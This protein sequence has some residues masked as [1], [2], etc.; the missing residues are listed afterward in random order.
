MPPNGRG[1]RHPLPFSAGRLPGH[2]NRPDRLP[3]GAGEGSDDE[4]SLEEVLLK[5]QYEAAAACHRDNLLEEANDLF[6]LFGNDWCAVDVATFIM[7]QGLSRAAGDELLK[8]LKKHGINFGSGLP[9]EL[10]SMDKLYKMLDEECD[11]PFHTT[12]VEIPGW[13]GATHHCHITATHNQAASTV[14]AAQCR[15]LSILPPGCFRLRPTLI[16][17]TSIQRE[18]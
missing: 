16:L 7:N 3:R 2:F 4:P 9:T 1:R 17:Q 6:K 14:I 10:S 18:D 5:R 13:P 12:P 8:L 11:L 15:C